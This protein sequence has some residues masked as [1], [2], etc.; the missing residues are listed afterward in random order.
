MTTSAAAYSRPL[1]V[2]PSLPSQTS[3]PVLGG[4]HHRGASASSMSHEPSGGAAGGGGGGG[5]STS[6]MSYDTS[7]APDRT[8]SSPTS[9][10][11]PDRQTS[12][13]SCKLGLEQTLDS[14]V[15]LQPLYLGSLDVA[16]P[17]TPL[18]TPFSNVQR[19]L[20]APRSLPPPLVPHT[21]SF[22]CAKCNN[23]VEHDTNLLLLSD[24]LPVCQN[25]SYICSTC[26]KSIDNSAVVTGEHSYHTECF[27]CCH[28]AERIEGLTY[29]KTQL[30]IWCMAC[31]NERIA[32]GR[33]KTEAKKAARA[34]RK[35]E[36]EAGRTKAERD[37]DRSERAHAVAIAAINGSQVPTSSG[38]GSGGHAKSASSSSN[39]ALRKSGDYEQGS[40]DTSP[41]P[42]DK[43]FSTQQYHS[44]D[45]SRPNS[46]PQT[47]HWRPQ[48]TPL[49][50]SATTTAISSL[51]GRLSSDTKDRP[52]R[53]SLPI[54]PQER[55]PA[56]S[57][58][59]SDDAG[60]AS[61]TFSAYMVR[62][63][64]ESSTLQ[65]INA[66]Q[67]QMNRRSGFYGFAQRPSIDDAAPVATDDLDVAY[68][69]I[70]N[71][72]EPVE[73]D[74]RSPAKENNV[75]E[76]PTEAL[77][78]SAPQHE[79]PAA[80]HPP[81]STYLPDL[82]NSMSFYD[83]DTL[84]FLNHVASP[85]NHSASN[86]LSHGPTPPRKSLDEGKTHSQRRGPSEA[87]TASDAIE[88]LS[89]DLAGAE[90]DSSRDVATAG[91]RSVARKVRE[92]IRLSRDGMEGKTGGASLDVELVE[93]LL[94]ELEETKK[95]M[96]EWQ[97]RYDAF[98]RA[99]KTAF[100]G[101]SMARE[102]YDREV[103]TRREVESR[104]EELR[105]RF[106]EQARRLADVD[107]DQK[108]RE[109]LRSQTQEL[110]SSVVATERQL[111]TLRAEVELSTAQAAELKGTESPTKTAND[112]I[113]EALNERLEEVK[114]RHRAE[115]TA[116]VE[117]RD[118]LTREVDALQDA[119]SFLI[120]ESA[121][122][123]ARHVSLEGQ[124]VEASKLL[125]SL[126]DQMS[127]LRVSPSPGPSGHH[128]SAS[129]SSMGKMALPRPSMS[130]SIGDLE[131]VAR[132]EAP[133]V[134]KFK[135][136]KAKAVTTASISSPQLQAG[137]SDP[138]DRKGS[139]MGLNMGSGAAAAGSSRSPQNSRS[140]SV[141]IDHGIRSH[142]FQPTSILR[143]IRCEYCGDK[144]WGLNEVR[145]TGCGCYS[146]TKCIPYLL[147]PCSHG[148]T[149][150]ASDDTM[151][152]LS[153][154]SG[155]FGNH[156]T[157]QARSE[158]REVPLVVS[159]CIAAVEVFGMYQEGIY[160]KSGGMGQT[161][162]ITQLF[163][164][165]QDFN[166]EDGNQFNDP[167]AITS[168][169]KNYF[170]CLPDPLFTFDLHE[171]FVSCTEIPSPE[172][173]LTKIEATLAKMPEV[174]YK[175]ARCLIQHLHRV[176]SRSAENKMTPVNLGV[177]F[178]PTVMRS[179]VVER[180]WS[181][182]GAKA[183]MIELLVENSPRFF[184]VA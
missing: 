102:E 112:R 28:C 129:I 126:R 138:H 174:H 101:F 5:A 141:S 40:Y 176:H 43:E 91:G 150:L 177:V 59:A 169:L 38:S 21:R 173:R 67:K 7:F 89:P 103:A 117:Q 75:N 41:S 18:W 133:I 172:D 94:N 96:Q 98:R 134:K 111:S 104:L 124:T 37:K 144:M 78:Y 179:R 92:S 135:W 142:A 139:V 70:G 68:E 82:H 51:G 183:K 1:P 127:K 58:G 99:S 118:A 181:D 93:M 9:P 69:R 155:M 63:E 123:Q 105:T 147:T 15:G 167:A 53:P 46:S 161:K 151:T 131:S 165:G 3:T 79:P 6:S 171:E 109:S 116:L 97:S 125:E 145:C 108:T 32:Q 115:I 106:V 178:G 30:G 157:A 52:P 13:N 17:L 180:E 168:C 50:T 130:P 83:P 36:K 140:A 42:K 95:E 120:D 170:R 49:P 55:S 88:H 71:E 11:L 22:R 12:C 54:P 122:L 29:A 153:Q 77:P 184:G 114:D 14:T 81:S 60:G 158:N 84:L 128:A 23:L 100:E 175:T 62:R 16:D 146:H 74:D 182:M 64:S 35:K 31:H 76:D 87:S 86:S 4:G 20:C 61:P 26:H 148:S 162:R 160:R 107:Q 132:L 2:P 143:P 19:R 154:F 137:S 164:S 65:P 44:H 72:E 8:P 113:V 25:C 73:D 121:T 57:V 166:L 33:K 39:F 119:R 80:A 34:G 66:E 85:R 110:R 27:R 149:A 47:L 45:T 10:F 152:L 24:G 156:L 163:E 48:H 56:I 90:F 159:K 136:G